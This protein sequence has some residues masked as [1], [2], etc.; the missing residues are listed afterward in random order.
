[1]S[2]SSRLSF[3]EHPVTVGETYGEHFRTA[4][5]F[6]ARM[7]EGGLACLVHAF[8]PFFSE[9]TG[10][11]TIRGLHKRMISHRS[12][13]ANSVPTLMPA[14]NQAQG[15]SASGRRLCARVS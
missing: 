1:M 13:A 6:S 3:T 14:S 5:G 15:N 4:M 12:R 11:A 7:V 10:S 9:R 2:S 8:F